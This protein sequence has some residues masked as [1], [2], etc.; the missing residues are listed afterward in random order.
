MSCGD[1][2]GANRQDT[3]YKIALNDMSGGD[4]RSPRLKTISEETTTCIWLRVKLS[5]EV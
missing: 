2:Q 1:Q 5:E 4:H 3:T